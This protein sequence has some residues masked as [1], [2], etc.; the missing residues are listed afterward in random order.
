VNIPRNYCEIYS[1][2]IL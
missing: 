2:I 1:R